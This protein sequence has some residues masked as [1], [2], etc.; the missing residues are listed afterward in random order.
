MRIKLKKYKKHS[1]ISNA[2]PNPFDSETRINIMIKEGASEGLLKI[3]NLQGK[4]VY[5]KNIRSRGEKEVII[6]SKNNLASG[7]YLYALIVDGE[8]IKS[9]KLIIK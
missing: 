2:T 9:N 4:E 7:S 1:S 6:I 5:S 3:Y 8:I